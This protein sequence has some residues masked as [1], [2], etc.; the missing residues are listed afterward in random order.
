MDEDEI[1]AR[2]NAMSQPEEDSGGL[3]QAI[4]ATGSKYVG[5]AFEQGSSLLSGYLS[6]RIDIDLNARALATGGTS[7]MRGD[8]R[9]INVTA[10]GGQVGAGSVTVGYN[11]KAMMPYLIVGAVV[12]LAT[13]KR[14]G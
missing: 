3:L 11:F 7:T 4:T 1:V 8:Q 6:R 2:I 12:W 13:K 5:S 9:P 14:A 10:T